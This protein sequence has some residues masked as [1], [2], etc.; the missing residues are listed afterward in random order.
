M[1]KIVTVFP[2]HF[3]ICGICNDLP[4]F[5]L[6]VGNFFLFLKSLSLKFINFNDF[7]KNVSLGS[8]VLLISIS[9]TSVFNLYYFSHFASFVF[10]LLFPPGFLK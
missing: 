8:V 5:A 7:F 6:G 3:S 10:N 9:M 4:L 2:Y 1:V